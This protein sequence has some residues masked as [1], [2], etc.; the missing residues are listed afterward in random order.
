MG[1]V[2]HTTNN[3]AFVLQAFKDAA[4]DTAQELLEDIEKVV[5]ES[6][7]LPKSGEV[8]GDHVAS[9][10]GDSPAIDTEDL[11]DSAVISPVVDGAGEIEYTSDHASHMEHGTVFIE[12][13]PFL[14]PGVEAV[15]PTVEEKYIQNLKKR[16]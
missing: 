13:R 11:V 10:A 3:L 7:R 4:D 15:R 14:A 6:M 1:I 9:E 12:A 16:L 5:T 2:V 8:Y